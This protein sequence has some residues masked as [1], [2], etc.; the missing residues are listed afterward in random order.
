[1]IHFKSRANLGR[2]IRLG[3]ILNPFFSTDAGGDAEEWVLKLV[4]IGFP[5]K[6]GEIY[7]KF[8]ML[9]AYLEQTFAST[10]ISDQA[11]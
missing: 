1:M 9:N 5:A 8:W 11:V 6:G 4:V 7:C 10:V 2:I 3:S